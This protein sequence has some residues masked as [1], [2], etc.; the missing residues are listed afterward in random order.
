MARETC[1]LQSSERNGI[2]RK[3]DQGGARKT[4][5]ISHRNAKTKITLGAWTSFA[6]VSSKSC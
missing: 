2:R 6:T 4:K 1:S 5:A 3:K